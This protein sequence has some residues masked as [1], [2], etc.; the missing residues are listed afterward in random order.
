M[1]ESRRRQIEKDLAVPFNQWVRPREDDR[2]GS[3]LATME[4]YVRELLDDA[5]P[6]CGQCAKLR[7]RIEAARQALSN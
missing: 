3:K 6:D 1:N 2:N 7:S 4:A 5:K